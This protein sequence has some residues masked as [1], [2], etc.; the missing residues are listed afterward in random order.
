MS[1]ARQK[2]PFQQVTR[3][4]HY[5]PQFYVNSWVVNGKCWVNREGKIFSSKPKNI[6]YEKD[7][8]TI[9]KL[10]SAE[11]KV[12]DDML[13]GS[14]SELNKTIKETISYLDSL[15]LMD[16]EQIEPLELPIFLEKHF[17]LQL[18][19][20]GE[21]LTAQDFL[22]KLAKENHADINKLIKKEYQFNRVQRAEEFITSIENESNEIYKMLL[23]DDLSFMN[24]LETEYDF[25]NFLTLMLYRTAKT[26][27]QIVSQIKVFIDKVKNHY[28]QFGD[29]DAT[30]IYSHFIFGQL[31]NA[32]YL[33]MNTP[34]IK[35]TIFKSK[36]KRF[37]TSDQPV[38]NINKSTDAEGNIIQ[39]DFVFPIS[40]SKVLFVSN[41]NKTNNVVHVDDIVVDYLNEQIRQHSY[42]HIIGIDKD[43][44]TPPS[45]E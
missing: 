32:I 2:P 21:N 5:V 36:G 28:P 40:S 13:Y 20:N 7:F 39:M 45:E 35:L 15:Y 42:K 14:N 30:K 4:Q 6:L 27:D 38:F 34:E 29:C 17:G 24:N 31:H 16:F 18:K 11:K 10:T 8:Y 26:R 9:H 1:K 44:V 43:S 41:K 12:R 3:K 25:Y 37:I 19:L 23:D 33:L 22:N